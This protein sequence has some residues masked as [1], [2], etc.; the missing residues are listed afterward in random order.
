VRPYEQAPSFCNAGSRRSRNL[1][2]DHAV[3]SRGIAL[4]IGARTDTLDRQGEPSAMA[5]EK[6]IVGELINFRGLVYAP[7]NENGVIF[8]FG[9][10]TKDL[11]MYIEEIKPGFPDC[12]ARRY[13]GRGWERVLIEFEFR[14]SNFRQHGHPAP[15]CDIIVCWEHDWKDC[16]IDVIELRSEIRDMPNEPIPQPTTAA[17]PVGAGGQEALEALFAARS[18][19][20]AVQ[21]WYGQ[22]EAALGELDPEIW[23][24]IG[25]K[26]V[27]IYSPERSF[28]S[29]APQQTVL[30]VK[31]FSRGESLPGTKVVNAKRAP[32]WA[33]F[34]IKQ[35]SQVPEAI[36]T[37][38]EAH[39]R[40]KAAMKAG[41]RTSY[42]SGAIRSDE[43]PELEADDAA[44]E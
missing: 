16:P 35:D 44:E 30:Q 5:H 24:N 34:T 23:M 17:T 31:C 29:L 12:V 38:R 25:D 2:G 33:A 21:K 13:T 37:L 8:L 32:R 3:L 18:A 36:A 28:A 41:E 6:S 11:H 19:S 26:Q 10:V 7:M 20:Q 15:G 43:E 1:P 40:L 22:I 4:P 14:S 9:R 42:F 27:G 39:A